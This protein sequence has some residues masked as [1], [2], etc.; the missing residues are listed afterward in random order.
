V[1]SIVFC[2]GGVIGLTAAMMLA[3]DGH[4]IIV[5]EGDAPPVPEDASAA[6]EDWPRRG[7]AQFHQPHNLFPR[8]RLI[9]EAELPDVLERLT[10][11][12]CVWLDPMRGLPPGIT[13]RSPR[14]G[15]DDFRFVTG[16]RP[17][18]EAAVAQA[19]ADEPGVEVRRG[20]RAESLI[21]G[22]SALGGVP[23]VAGVRTSR[24]EEL[25][26]DLV[27]DAMGRHTRLAE[28]L[29]AL[30][31]RPP[32][33]DAEDSRFVYYTRYFTGPELPVPMAPPVCEI[34]SISVLTLPGDN[35]T[36]SVTLFGAS[37]DVPLRQVKDPERFT[38]V[39]Q[40][41]PLHAHWLDGTAITEVLSMAG[42][43]DRYRR[44][45]PDGAPVATGV[46]AV[47]DAWACT[48]PSAGRGIT[49]GTVH[50]QCLR[51]VVG[52]HLDDPEGFV[53][54]WDD[55]TERQVAPF[56]WAQITAD[57]ARI[58]Q[59]DALRAGVEPP[60]VAADTRAIATAAMR[61]PDVFRA[62]LAAR[63]CLALPDDVFSTPGFREKVAA[64]E[65]EPIT[66]PGPDRAAL[67]DLLA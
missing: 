32:A 15:D 23:H 43:L 26:A 10:A 12:G 6:W 28:W 13:D 27:V 48:N 54:E 65:G 60:P 40:A 29:E 4:E 31:G 24:G 22:Q 46:A 35:D 11:A 66:I 33:L 49:V 7:V 21:G 57:R 34:G 3:R 20:V 62:A 67:L 25:A 44:F 14:P 45:V 64:V 19:A 55:V 59:V 58:A 16:R 18:V 1:A 47:G 63:M 53:R 36:W 56:Y 5:L 37:A 9:L 61:D 30:D 41:C 39:V 42:I 51:D 38:R 52:S 50:A 2:G 8:N 17:V